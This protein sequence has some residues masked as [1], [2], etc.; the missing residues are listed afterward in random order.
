MLQ[1]LVL[2][3]LLCIYRQHLL[4]ILKLYSGLQ[5]YSTSVQYD[6]STSMWSINNKL[7][8]LPYLIIVIL[9]L[10]YIQCK[11]HELVGKFI[12]TN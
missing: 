4:L 8:L 7:P 3:I 1:L 5:I 9:Q 2:L 11:G 12:R 6:K 10:V